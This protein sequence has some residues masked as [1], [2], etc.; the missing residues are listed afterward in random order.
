MSL[1]ECT[2][3]D[4]LGEKMTVKIAMTPKQKIRLELK[5]SKGFRHNHQYNANINERDLNTDPSMTIKETHLRGV[6]IK[7]KPNTKQRIL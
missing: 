3:L 5:I 6:H 2:G 1:D 7:T 4:V